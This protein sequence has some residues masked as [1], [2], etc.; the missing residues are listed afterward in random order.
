MIRS[1]C[2]LPATG[3]TC[4]T[5]IMLIRIARRV[6][7]YAVRWI[8]DA[9]AEPGDTIT[10][11]RHVDAMSESPGPPRTARFD[12]GPLG[13]SHDGERRDLEHWQGLQGVPGKSTACGAGWRKPECGEALAPP[14]PWRRDRQGHSPTGI[15]CVPRR[16]WI[17]PAKA[18]MGRQL[19]SAYLPLSSC[20][21]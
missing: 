12:H 19:S 18:M 10:Q 2:I 8:F 1:C 9:E 13:L 15:R 16:A 14:W 20:H 17:A 6:S 3:P 4:Q 5:G 7:T 11:H 21:G